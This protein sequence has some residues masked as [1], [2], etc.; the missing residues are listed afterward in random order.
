MA[1]S[2]TTTSSSRRVARDRRA[3]RRRLRPA[4]PALPHHHP[5]LAGGQRLRAARRLS[6][7][8]ARAPGARQRFVR[9]RRGARPRDGACHRQPRHRAPE[10][11]AER[12]DRQP[13]RHRRARRRAGSSRSP[14]ASA[15][16]RAS[17][18]SRSSRP[19]RSASRPSAGPATTP[20]PR[21]ASS[22]PWRS[23]RAYKTAAPM[24]EKRPDFLASH[25]S[26]PERVDFATRAAREF[27]APGVGEVDR[28]RYLDGIDGHGLRRRSEPGLRPRAHLHPPHARRRL[29]RAGRLRHRQ[30]ERR[31]ARDRRRRHGAPLRRGGAGRAAP[32]SAHYLASGWVN[33][34][35]ET[36]RHALHGQRPAGGVGRMPAPRAGPSGSRSSRPI[37]RDL[38]LHLRQR[39][40]RP[41]AFEKAA[42]ETVAS[43]RQL[44]QRTLASLKPLTHQLVTVAAGDTREIARARGCAAST[45]RANC[46]VSSTTSRPGTPLAPGTKVKIVADR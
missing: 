2:T 16:S 45:G 23:T 20:S 29:H 27:G 26:T 35:D 30:C 19:T 22:P 31:G 38:P 34:L 18:A 39:G 17:R 11:G 8:H 36:Q 28:D 44:D 40:R 41:P 6:L 1:A 46:S 32:T 10:Q 14:R 7:R 24:M 5:Q 21:R 15:R 43:F 4:G 9:G 12:G 42:A 13:R 25:P 37:G 33:G 3:D